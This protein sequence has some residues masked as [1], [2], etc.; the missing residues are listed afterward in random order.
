MMFKAIVEHGVAELQL[1]SWAMRLVLPSASPICV[2]PVSL[3]C[4]LVARQRG[5]SRKAHRVALVMN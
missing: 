2:V 3:R 5:T 4:R 1:L